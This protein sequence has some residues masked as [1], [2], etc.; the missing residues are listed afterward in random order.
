MCVSKFWSVEQFHM[1]MDNIKGVH[2]SH[3]V[4]TAT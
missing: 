3:H 2:V 4:S 1:H